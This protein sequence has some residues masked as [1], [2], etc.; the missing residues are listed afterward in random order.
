MQTKNKTDIQKSIPK[1]LLQRNFG[2]PKPVKI[3]Q[4]FPAEKKANTGEDPKGKLIE[5]INHDIIQPLSKK[6]LNQDTKT[7]EISHS[8]KWALNTTKICPSLDKI[9]KVQQ[10]KTQN[11][12]FEENHPEKNI[13]KYFKTDHISIKVPEKDIKNSTSNFLEIKG[14]FFVLNL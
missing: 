8:L 4:R 10:Y 5:F 2:H 12:S 1:S 13:K 11:F 14:I 7:A 9:P 3:P 6:I